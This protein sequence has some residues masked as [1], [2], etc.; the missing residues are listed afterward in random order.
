MCCTR[1][2][3]AR[4]DG[5]KRQQPTRSGPERF[6][7]PSTCRSHEP[8]RKL[9]PLRT[10]SRNIYPPPTRRTNL[11]Q[12]WRYNQADWGR[13]RK[14]FRDANWDT[15]IYDDPDEACC[16]VTEKILEGMRQ[17]IPQKR[18]L[19]RPSDPSWWTPE[20]TS[21]VR[22]KQKSWNRFQKHPSK[23]NEDMYKAFSAQ[24]AIC[25]RNARNREIDRVRC[26]L[27][28]GSMKNKQWWSTLKAAGGDGRQCS[29]PVIRD[30]QGREHTTNKDKAECFGRFFSTKCSLRND[31]QRSNLPAFPNRCTAALSHV[32]FHPATVARLLRQLDLSK[33]TGPGGIPARV[34]KI[35]AAEL[36]SLLSSLFSACFRQGVY[37]SLWKT[38]NVVPVHKKQARSSM[39]NYRPV[40][41]LSVVSK[42]MEKVINVNTT[43]M[44]HLEKKRLLS[45]HQFGF[46][47]GLSAADLLA[48]L[49]HQWLSCMNTG[50][51]VRTL[52]V[53]I[54]GAFDKVSHLGVLHKLRSYGIAGTLHQWMT[55]YLTDRNL[56]VVV[57]GATS[58]HFPV[59]AGVPQGSILGPTLFP[60]YVNDA[61]DVLPPG[62]V[63][64][65][66]A[67]DTTLYV[68]IPSVN[69]AATSCNTLQTGMDA[70]AEWGTTWRIQFEPSKSQAMTITRHRHQWP[71]PAGSF[72]G[73]NVDE[74]ATI[75]LLGVVFDKSMSF[76]NHLRSVAMRAA[77]RLGFLRKACRVLDI[78]GRLTAYKG[79]VRPLMECS[80]L[81]LGGAAP[82]SPVSTGQNPTSSPR[83]HRSGSGYRQPGTS[84]NHQRHL[85]HLQT[86]VWTACPLPA[87]ITASS[88]NT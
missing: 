29:I 76:R 68:L 15:I 42:V 25:L 34:L 61:A 74:T 73:L 36:S 48:H 18:L 69:H 55:S 72:G 28:Q 86:D 7:R 53:D 45:Q 5:H 47:T 32:R 77:Q 2:P 63:P 24:S 41:L 19:T 31:L 85:L 75:K 81:A 51:A 8:H 87:D 79:L 88:V 58:S 66:Y 9:R 83:P 12:V 37:P 30:D 39:R 21:A 62:A 3:P 84:P 43:L 70:L 10:V 14:F 11:R 40:S 44:N 67:D 64:A 27:Q 49:S 33:A 17:F 80:P 57:G 38:A 82:S 65:T 50:G 23:P 46:R 60:V 59:T 78:S 16:A 26:R 52:A 4:R 1:T 56:Q 35:C 13:L 6:R 54:A 20:C 71:I 22:A